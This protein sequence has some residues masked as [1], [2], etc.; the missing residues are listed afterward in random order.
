M[1]ESIRRLLHR[2][3]VIA[4]F[5]VLI[6]MEDEMTYAEYIRFQEWKEENNL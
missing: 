5:L 2:L 3:E 6:L 1:I 4:T